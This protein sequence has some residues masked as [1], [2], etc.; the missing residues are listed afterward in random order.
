[1][2]AA[3]LLTL[4]DRDPANLDYARAR[5][6][7]MP[8]APRIQSVHADFRSVALMMP[9]GTPPANAVLADLGFASTQVDDP[10]RGLAFSHDGPLDLR[11]DPTRGQT[12][13]QPGAPRDQR[14]PAGI[15]IPD[16]QDPFRRRITQ[17]HALHP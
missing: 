1:M 13:P 14:Q 3:G 2:G 16:G 10:S 5:V 17:N 8:A 4:F 6:S 12:A 15:S 7:A 11:P 9:S